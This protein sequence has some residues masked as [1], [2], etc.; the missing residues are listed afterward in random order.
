MLSA[1]HTLIEESFPI[2]TSYP[3]GQ[4]Y[5][6]SKTSSLCDLM[7]TLK[8]L[9]SNSRRDN[10]PLADRTA[11]SFPSTLISQEATSWFSATSEI[12]FEKS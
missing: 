5:A 12:S 9:E 1:C 6:T 11:I 7:T 4:L 3:V 8:E 2:E 10:V